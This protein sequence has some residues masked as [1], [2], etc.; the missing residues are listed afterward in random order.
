[1]YQKFA[2]IALDS[3]KDPSSFEDL[4]CR[5]MQNE[6]YPFIMQIG[7]CHDLGVDAEIRSL[8]IN[9]DRSYVFQFSIQKTSRDK[10]ISTINKLIDNNINFR[11]FIYV[12]KVEVTNEQRQSLEKE[13]KTKYNK[14]L[15]IYERKTIVLRLSQTENGLLFNFFPDI[16]KNLASLF[17]EKKE[18]IL[19]KKN[20]FET[21]CLKCALTFV[22][23]PQ[24]NQT[25]KSIFDYLILAVLYF[26][27]EAMSA[28]E[29]VI[30]LNSN[31]DRK[32]Y[33]RNQVLIS[34]ERLKEKKFIIS[35][36][37]KYCIKENIKSDINLF[38]SKTNDYIGMLIETI[39]CKIKYIFKS[40]ISEITERTIRRNITSII[41]EILGKFSIEF[42]I[43]ILK[44]DSKC[45]LDSYEDKFNDI[46]KLDLE[47]KYASIL[48]SVLSETLSN[49]NEEQEELLSKL[50]TSHIGLMIMNHNPMLNG[51]QQS[52][53]SEKVF[54]L[55]TEYILNGILTDI[56]ENNSY[57]SPIKTPIEVGVEVIVPECVIEECVNHARS[58]IRYYHYNEN[59]STLPE[60]Y[61]K[62]NINNIFVR[63][64]YYFMKLN[65]SPSGFSFENY[66]S[67]YYSKDDPNNFFK[68]VLSEILGNKIKILKCS[69]ILDVSNEN[70]L[71]DAV[72][73]QMLSLATDSRPG[74]LNNEFIAK[75]DTEIFLLM[76]SAENQKQNKYY[77]L[78]DSLRY[79]KVCFSLN[80]KRFSVINASC[81]SSFLQFITGF[82]SPK[83]S[84]HLFSQLLAFS[85]SQVVDDIKKLLNFGANLS[86]F[87][88]SRLRKD[89][90]E[91]LHD[92]LVNI[93]DAT[94]SQGDI[95]NKN[96]RELYDSVL[97]LGY[98][99]E[100]HR[101]HVEELNEKILTRDE[102]INDLTRKMND[103][104]RKG[105]RYAKRVVNK[106][107]NR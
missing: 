100:F 3:L 88:L 62:T 24:A 28:E 93:D 37:E 17:S 9:D 69:Q 39:V 94:Y 25:R 1:M 36:S 76:V 80:I 68:N 38:S 77:L 5:I 42:A 67:N 81:L 89:L 65:D 13:V 75:H 6:G 48:L 74:S 101:R 41:N 96:V 54:I 95:N 91:K 45:G 84:N 82:S 26:K 18:F 73:N 59:L 60:F 103:M 90:E 107:K 46:A 31:F 29:I 32:N 8:Y 35:S 44:V 55:D 47:D 2:E 51:F 106:L 64:Y 27:K 53:I 20:E 78:S 98:L 104:G 4:C 85:V 23:H 19:K 11:T 58:S 7:G 87:N 83:I 70:Q 72:Y 71:E 102:A 57:I 21:A 43:N 79:K 66:L 10:I 16:E 52:K 92:K 56:P 12:T 105:S 15:I 63:G 49:P 14:E 33:D 40:K 30:E 61:V 50:I 86:Y 22:Y 97:E 99:G 34:L